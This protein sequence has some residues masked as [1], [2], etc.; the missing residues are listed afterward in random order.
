M[1]VGLPGRLSDP[2]EEVGFG[3]AVLPG[4]D[5]DPGKGEGL[6]R[7]L[8]DLGDVIGFAHGAVLVEAWC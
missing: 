7:H 1:S 6:L 3:H 8:G 2:G 4:R 5:P